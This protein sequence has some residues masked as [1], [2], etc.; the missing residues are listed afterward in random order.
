MKKKIFFS[1]KRYRLL[2]T[3]RRDVHCA[4]AVC[5]GSHVG[6]TLDPG[7][8]FLTPYV[9]LQNSVF[10]YCWDSS[11]VHDQRRIRQWK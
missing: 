2:R 10:S 8:D 11:T 9:F 3:Q 4:C 1:C 6:A 7:W 5:S